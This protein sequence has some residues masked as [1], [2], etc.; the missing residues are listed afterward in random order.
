MHRDRQ[1]SAF[2]GRTGETE[3][4]EENLHLPV[5]D[6][7]RR[8]IVA[9]SGQGGMGKTTF[10]ARCRDIAASAGLATAWSNEEDGDLVSVMSRLAEDFGEASRFSEFFK[11][12]NRYR[13]KRHEV[14]SDPDA[15]GEL[16]H[17]IGSATGRVGTV[18]ARRI[19][20]AGAAFDLMG[21]DVMGQQLT[22]VA[23][24]VLKK[25]KQREDARL[26]LEPVEVLTPLFLTGVRS[27]M[28]ERT[29]GFFFDTFEETRHVVEPWLLHLLDGHFGAISA[30]FMITVAGRL[31]LS[32]DTWAP[33]E[34]FVARIELEPLSPDES[35]A[36]LTRKGMTAEK[37]V[38]EVVTLAQG[39]PIFLVSLTIGTPDQP[40]VA[41]T[42]VE[43]VLRSV[44]ESL[45]KVAIKGAL[46]RVLNRDIGRLIMEGPEP[47]TAFD[48]LTKM[49]FVQ[50]TSDGWKY[51]NVIRHEFLR[52]GKRESPSEWDEAQRKL[53]GYYKERRDEA[54]AAKDG[55]KVF[56]HEIERM[57]H[58]IAG[59]DAE[60]LK[61]A[62]NWSLRAW[63]ATRALARAPATALRDAEEDS[64]AES[65]WGKEWLEAIDE[66]DRGHDQP[67]IQLFTQL[68][69]RAPLEEEARINAL[70]ARGDL[71]YAQSRLDASLADIETAISLD[72]QEPRLPYERAWIHAAAGRSELALEDFDRAIEMLDEDDSRA[73]RF[74]AMR[75][76][77]VRRMFTPETALAQINDVLDEAEDPVALLTRGRILRDLGRD[78]EAIADFEQVPER[79]PARLHEAREEIGLTHLQFGRCDEAVAV[80]RPA[81]ISNPTCETCWRNLALSFAGAE[82]Q[83]AVE[84]LL[85]D[86]SPDVEDPVVHAY[87]GLGLMEVDLLRAARSELEV[88]IHSDPTNPNFRLW[89][90]RVLHRSHTTNEGMRQVEEA[91]RLRSDWPEALIL[92]GLLR[93]QKGDLKSAE[94]DWAAAERVD[95]SESGTSGVNAR[96]LAL[97]VLGRYEDAIRYFDRA[98]ADGPNEQ[99][100]YNRAVARSILVGC[101]EAREELRAAERA[102]S[103]ADE[104]VVQQYGRAGIKCV[105]GDD[106]GALR[107]LAKALV[108]DPVGVRKWARDDPAWGRMRGVEPF[109]QVLAGGAAG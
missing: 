95:P 64:G 77:V 99:A 33:Y 83:K 34:G 37:T 56:W 84:Q 31:S 47:D 78:G 40:Q 103:N 38:E 88:A 104:A 29:V 18:L 98:L 58:G 22:D 49:P 76:A 41:D 109:E 51:H 55:Q 23:A 102:V 9:I 32:P 14:E 7:R 3:K 108:T 68:L 94:D 72:G 85:L 6:A 39:V 21:D 11:A 106:D 101:E 93:A 70:V 80:L 42:A 13:E 74:R 91:L 60:A 90:A 105:L 89:L 81:V 67:A 17:V 25:T 36:F 69:E 44:P 19:P 8:S 52:H 20:I 82:E 35:R 87:R 26:I 46:P 24:F 12:R 54:I 50:S 16:A 65:T 48:W 30:N 75:V 107:E 43:R 63:D 86:T 100:L 71:Y 57:Y 66:M 2:V 10:M 97:S 53:E 73:T 96:G 27:I 45:R 59:G 1:R 5:E 28:E 92:R 79:A 15:P 61:Q 4:F 62:I